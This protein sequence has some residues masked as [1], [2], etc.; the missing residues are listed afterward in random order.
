M[1][2]I[3]AKHMEYYGIKHEKQP[4]GYG[5]TQIS[6]LIFLPAVATLFTSVYSSQVSC[7]FL[8]LK[9]I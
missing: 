7:E 2:Y 4:C 3:N 1:I 5:A 8:G 9:F 6:T